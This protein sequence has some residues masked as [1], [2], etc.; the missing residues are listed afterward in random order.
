MLIY[1]LLHIVQ[2]ITH[3]S[4]TILIFTQI[5]LD[6]LTAMLS[7]PLQTLLILFL[8]FSMSCILLKTKQCY[9]T[10]AEG[11]RNVCIW[12]KLDCVYHLLLCGVI[13]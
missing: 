6:Y 9:G 12:Q 2:N 8:P 3:R 13:G 10:K 11:L 5:D 4:I 7:S 1:L